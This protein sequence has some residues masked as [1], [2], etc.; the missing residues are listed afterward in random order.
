MLYIDVLHRGYHPIKGFEKS[1]RNVF[2]PELNEGNFNRE[3]S[4]TV[5]SSTEAIGTIWR[6]LGRQ[7]GRPIKNYQINSVQKQLSDELDTMRE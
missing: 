1:A 7:L 6:C 3:D 4:F 5:V 2:R